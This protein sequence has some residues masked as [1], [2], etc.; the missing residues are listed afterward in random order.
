MTRR[1]WFLV[2]LAVLLGSVYAYYLTDWINTP[3][4][5]II[6]SERPVQYRRSSQRILPVTFTFDGRYALTAVRV[7]P[8]AAL[9]TNKH[10]VPLWH[11]TTKSNSP[12]L[13]GFIYGQPIRG[14]KPVSD[15]TRA[16]PLEPGVTYRLYVEAGRARGET[17]FQAHAASE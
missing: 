13:K 3:R 1:T 11:L 14:L 17:D 7:V 6:K 4:I 12:P 8:V 5:Q 2:T 10:P 9:A 15:Q 16:Q